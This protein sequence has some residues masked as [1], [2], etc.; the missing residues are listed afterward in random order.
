MPI[1]VLDV[2]RS[3]VGEKETYT[4]L[5]CWEAG[6]AMVGGCQL[7]G[8]TIAVYNAY[9]SQSGYWRCAAC[10]G[11]TGFTSIEEFA[12]TPVMDCPACANVTDIREISD[13]LFECGE[14]GAE[15]T[16]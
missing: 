14:C 16:L 2:V 6:V 12:T 5:D 10:I 4:A 7:C 9:P 15:W 3:V 13:R 1:T 11:S 8:A